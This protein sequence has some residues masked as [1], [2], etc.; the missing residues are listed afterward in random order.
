MRAFVLACL[1][2]H[3]GKQYRR[4]REDNGHPHHITMQH[5]AS[6]LQYSRGRG[7]RSG[8]IETG[9]RREVCLARYKNECSRAREALTLLF[10]FL[11]G[12]VLVR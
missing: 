7:F 2:W 10:P 5:N 6:L 12:F 4:Q 8:T 11:L 3:S 1:S 9:R